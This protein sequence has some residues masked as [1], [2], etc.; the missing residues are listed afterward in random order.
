MAGRRKIRTHAGNDR[1]EVGRKRDLRWTLK[2][3][4]FGW[5]GPSRVA[6]VHTYQMAQ[7]FVSG[8]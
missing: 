6:A 5:G 3:V 1:G 4:G 7:G 8:K 2:G